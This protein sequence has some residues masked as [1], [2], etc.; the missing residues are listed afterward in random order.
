[1]KYRNRSKDENQR[2][3][4]IK[5]RHK[6]S[7]DRRYRG[8]NWWH[9]SG[10]VAVYFFASDVMSPPVGRKIAGQCQAKTPNLSNTKQDFRRYEEFIMQ[11]A[12][13]RRMDEGTPTDYELLSKLED[14]FVSALPERIVNALKDLDNS[15][16][17]YQ[18]S[19]LEHS[20]QSASC[21]GRDGADI[22]MIVRA[23]IHDLG[24]DLA[25]LNHS[26]LA[27]AIIKPFVRS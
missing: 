9:N 1:M 10:A 16:V 11:R 18:I 12:S 22:E 5:H 20:L 23:F 21:A 27:A 7:V 19:R 2:H 15:L 4:S 3:S 13:F 17:G 6:A 8:S 26:Q 24:E 14:E 25:P